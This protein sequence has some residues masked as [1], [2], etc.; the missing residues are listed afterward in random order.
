ME[1]FYSHGKLLLTGEYLVLHGAVALALP[2][3]LGQSM[4]VYNYLDDFMEWVAYKPDGKW[5]SAK[6]VPDTLEAVETDNPAMASR[7]SEILKAVR[8][9]NPDILRHGLYFETR[10]E[11]DPEWGLGSSS[12]LINNLAQWAGVNPYKLL[13]LTFGGSGYDIACARAEGPILYKL[14]DH[15]PGTAKAAFN[16][17]FAD[18]LFF[19]Y[20]GQKQTSSVEVKNFNAQFNPDGHQD[21]TETVS[22]ISL[23]LPHIDRYSDFESLMLLHEVCIARC[24]GKTMVQEDY[25]DFPG[26][27]KSLGAWGGDFLM[28]VTEMPFEEVRDYFQAKGM[29][30]IFKDQ[31]LIL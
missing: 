1:T 20:Q 10:L 19:V 24:T 9:L 21:D 29:N 13:R 15:K 7:L 8:E 16:P 18:R 31:D 11:F 23:T 3:K 22:Q 28:A 5:F 14:I 2:T 4:T 6:I 12:T 27:L 17:P 26:E 30:T 25:P